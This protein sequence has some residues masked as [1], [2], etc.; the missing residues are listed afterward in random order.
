MHRETNPSYHRAPV[1]HPRYGPPP[2]TAPPF[3][4][5]FNSPNF[6]NLVSYPRPVPPPVY[7]NFSSETHYQTVAPPNQFPAGWTLQE[8]ELQNLEVKKKAEEFLRILEA[9]DRL[10]ISSE[11]GDKSTRRPSAD[12]EAERRSSEKHSR[13]RSRSRGKSRGKSRGRSRGKSRGKSRGRSRGRSRGKSRERSRGRSRGK[14]QERS[15]GRSRGKSRGKSQ[16]RSRGRSRGQ[17]RS[18]SRGK[19][20]N[21]AKSQPRHRSRSRGRSFTRSESQPRL[22]KGSQEEAPASVRGTVSDLFQNLKQV[23]QSR[24]LSV[25]KNT[26]MINQAQDDI[27]RT[28]QN[29]S[30]PQTE[31]PEAARAAHS[32][33][34][35]E[36]VGGADRALSWISSWNDPGQKNE[37]FQNKP[38]FSSIEDEEEFLYGDEEGR[39]KPQAVTVPLAQ[40]RPAENPTSSPC[41]SKPPVLQE[42]KGQAATSTRPTNLDMSAENCERLKN[43]LNNI[44][45]NLSPADISN[46]VTRLKQKQEEQRGAIS[47]TS[48]RATLETT[49]K[50]HKVQESDERQGVR[51]ESS[52]S[53]RDKKSEEK[54]KEQREKQIQKKRKEYLVKELEGLLKHEG[55]GDLIPV[56]GFFCQRCEEFFGDLRSAEGHKHTTTP[57][58]QHLKDDKRQRDQKATERRDQDERISERKRPREHMSPHRDEDQS[59]V[60][61][62]KDD[63]AQSSKKAKK[64]KKKE[65]KMKKKE[66][67]KEKKK[68]K[69]EKE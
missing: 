7:Q 39:K 43:L 11:S 22:P 53:H 57:P 2:G 31:S 29:L 5:P 68:D 26:I 48:L 20:C 13:G 52:L 65:K 69:A 4:G 33:L 42:H 18:R 19:S 27:R 66:K 44:R 15:R 54:E 58:D 34:P 50:H 10:D 24:E 61:D 28:S 17:S 67:K 41:L 47:N 45:L 51:S 35:H 64:K 49:L 37:A 56:I 55:S 12:P 46:L 14:S 3:P 40:T 38:V 36:R 8:D 16:A 30:E 63:D 25:V 32:V 23:L 6:P 1:P 62:T 59:R 9:K 60:Q 21:R